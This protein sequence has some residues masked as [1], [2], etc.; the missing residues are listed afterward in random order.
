MSCGTGA[1]YPGSEFDKL[2]A[3]RF[4]ELDSLISS[5]PSSPEI[6]AAVFAKKPPSCRPC[7]ALEMPSEGKGQTVLQWVA[8]FKFSDNID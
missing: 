8:F 7:S 3:S 4:N 6:P 5:S 2:F 1:N